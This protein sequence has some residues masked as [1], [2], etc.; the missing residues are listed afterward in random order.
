MPHPS[1]VVIRPLA[2][3]EWDR[4][5]DQTDLAFHRS[6]R[7]PRRDRMRT[8]TV[9]PDTVVADDGGRIVG[10]AAAWRWTVSVP[11]GELPCAG[12]TIVTVRPTHRR[13]GILRA[14]MARIADEARAAGE[15]LAAL[16]A[17]EGA[18]YGR[19]GYGVAARVQT[20]RVQTRGGVP[21]RAPVPEPLGVELLEPEDAHPVV[22]SIYERARARRGGIM[23]RRDADWWT[24]RVLGN[25]P[26]EIA[27]QGPLRVVV[28][29][30]DGYALYRV[31][32]G[33]ET[34][35]VS[36]WTTVHVKELV[37]ATAEAERTL[38]TYL[39]RI[40]LAD[41]VLLPGRPVDDALVLAPVDA[42]AV[43]PEATHDAL[44][45]RILDVPGAVAGRSWAADAQAVV[46]V[47]HPEDDHVAGRW[48]LRVGPDGGTAERTDA[49]PDVVLHARDLAAA[50]LGDATLTA[51]HDA[52]VVEE[53]TAGT[54][55]ALDAALRTDRAPWTVGVF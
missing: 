17:S 39:T 20:L 19:F 54:L 25:A 55:S 30:D 26:D 52:G 47:E 41:E 10:T 2:E 4:A 16:W 5:H 24:K 53:R 12:V 40:D 37:A 18:I 27:A 50:Y 48:A 49:A 15:P 8:W 38:L 36:A 31:E 13:R 35:P 1:D 6:T 46:E 3:G 33:A 44:W 51:L 34:S 9:Q 28:A 14:M 21:L 43:Q 11:G 7:G 32:E 42:R 22:A 29:G 23:S 45:L